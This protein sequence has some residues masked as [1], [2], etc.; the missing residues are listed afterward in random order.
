MFFLSCVNVFV[1]LQIDFFVNLRITEIT[2][3][4][5][6]IDPFAKLRKLV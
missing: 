3:V 4:L 5:V 2:L 1:S 6:Q